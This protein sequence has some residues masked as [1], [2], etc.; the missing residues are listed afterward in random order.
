MGYQPS[1]LL[2]IKIE[3]PMY[4]YEIIEILEGLNKSAYSGLMG[5]I[6]SSITQY[7]NS[8]GKNIDGLDSDKFKLSYKIEERIATIG[9]RHG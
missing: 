3:I 2:K 7:K 6:Y 9:G 4:D 5:E 8:K 1:N